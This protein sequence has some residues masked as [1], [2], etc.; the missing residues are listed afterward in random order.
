[1]PVDT[2]FAVTTTRLDVISFVFFCSVNQIS[3]PKEL[4]TRLAEAKLEK[5]EDS[6]I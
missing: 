4:R 5:Q 6:C 1:M 2:V 3:S